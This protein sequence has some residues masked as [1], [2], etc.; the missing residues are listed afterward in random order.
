MKRSIICAFALFIALL[1][2]GAHAGENVSP[3]KVVAKPAKKECKKTKGKCVK[4][5]V[6]KLKPKAKKKPKPLAPVAPSIE[7][8]Y[9]PPLFTTSPRM[10]FAVLAYKGCMYGDVPPGVDVVTRALSLNLSYRDSANLGGSAEKLGREVCLADALGLKRYETQADIDHAKGSTLFEVS[11]GFIDF[12]DDDGNR[13][14]AERRFARL[15]VKEYVERL[16]QD[17]HAH[18]LSKRPK[19]STEDVPLLRVNSLVRSLANQSEQHSPAKCK[20][21][22]CSTHLTGSTVDIANGAGRVSAEVR[23]WIRTRLLQDRKDGKIIMIQEFTRPHYHVF[24]I[25]P[26]Y[27]EW[28]KENPPEGRSSSPR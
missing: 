22:I 5:T 19:G 10:Q 17:L 16:A 27:V 23:K 2:G 24:V 3:E 12:P 26:E 4:Q 25:P 9:R 1:F 21:E 18:L 8:G 20:N 7:K 13:L 6:K 15:W 28:Y 14:P 11:S